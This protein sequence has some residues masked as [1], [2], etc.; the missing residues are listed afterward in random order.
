MSPYSGFHHIAAV[1]AA[2]VDEQPAQRSRLGWG[3]L[4]RLPWACQCY[5]RVEQIQDYIRGS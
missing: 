5:V 4:G 1:Y 3:Q 2:R